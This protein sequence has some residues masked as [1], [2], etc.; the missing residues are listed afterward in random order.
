MATEKYLLSIEGSVNSTE[1]TTTHV[2]STDD[3]VSDDTLTSAMDLVTAWTTECIDPWLAF[4]SEDY[5]VR[6]VTARRIN[7][8]GSAVGHRQFQVGG[9]V[10]Q[11]GEPTVAPNLAPCIRLIPSVMGRTAGRMFLP[12]P[13]NTMVNENL[14]DAAYQALVETYMD[15]IIAGFTD[16]YEWTLNIHHRKSNQFSAVTGYNL[17]P[18]LGFQGRRRYPVA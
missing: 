7:P 3:A 6:R 16:T 9:A 8:V 17:S 18:S 10:G 12:S 5:Q 1:M 15:T 14:Y 4:Q 2:M 11:I 13:P